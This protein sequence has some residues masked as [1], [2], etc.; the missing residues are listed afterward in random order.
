MVRKPLKII[1][2]EQAIL[3][4][5]DIYKFHQKVSVQWAEKVRDKIYQSPETVIYANQYQIDEDD[6]DYRR[7][8]VGDYKVLYQ[9][10][11]GN[12]NI[13]DVVCSLQ[14]SKTNQE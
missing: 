2:S 4:L 7:I 5:K 11:N 6:P 9:I 3:A 12:I 13:I 8:V 1:W 10:E 14:G